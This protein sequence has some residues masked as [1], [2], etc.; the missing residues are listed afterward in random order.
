MEPPPGPGLTQRKIRDSRIYQ[1]LNV[2]KPT[3][4]GMKYQNWENLTLTNTMCFEA[5]KLGT[6]ALN[7]A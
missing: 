5:S 4:M 1:G 6:S 3:E 2:I 7:G